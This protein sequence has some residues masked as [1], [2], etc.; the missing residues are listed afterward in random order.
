ME[1]FDI[2]P[3][4]RVSQAEED[5]NLLVKFYLHP[6]LDKKQTAEEGRPIYKEVEYIKINTPGSR[7]GFAGPA[8]TTDVQRFPE[9]YKAFKNRI[10]MPVEGT[11][12]SEWPVISRSLCEELAFFN[13][14]T[15]EALG[16]VA[17]SEISRIRGG[18]G[19]KQKAKNWLKTTNKRATV[20][21]LEKELAARDKM[22]EEMLERINKLE[23]EREQEGE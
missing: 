10:E 17:D 3:F 21:R 5:K 14:K 23:A 12:L 15:V 11:L 2:D 6:V 22:L 19:L 8:R 4:K 9:H 1:M 18:Q 7:D 20:A 16:T 13:I